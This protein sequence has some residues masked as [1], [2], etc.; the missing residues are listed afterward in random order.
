MKKTDFIDNYR[1]LPVGKY[2]EIVHICREEM[3]DVDRRVAIVSVLSGLTEDEVLRLP[4]DKFTEYS[5]KSR[6]IEVECPENMIPGVAR[7]YPIGGFVLLPVTD[8]RKITAAQYIDFQTF[9]QDRENKFVELL[10]C[11]LIPRG[12]EYNDGYDILDVHRAI[13]EEMSV[14]EC[15]ALL[16]FFFQRLAAVNSQYPVLF[17]TDGPED[18]E[19]GTEE[20]TGGEDPGPSGFAKRWGWYAHV[21]GISETM[22][23]SW[24]DVF[25]MPV[26]Q[27]LNMICYRNDK[28]EEQKR[29]IERWKKNN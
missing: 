16:A 6:F 27:F 14:A 29:E 5:A 17:G 9:A 25:K 7:N 23:I 20:G 28:A 21:D 2:E 12:C 24:D 11:F 4:L 13:R 10:S 18:K 26:L 19:Q 1:D 8:I 15:L 22:R 3:T